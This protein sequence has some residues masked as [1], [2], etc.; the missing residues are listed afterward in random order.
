LNGRKISPLKAHVD[1]NGDQL[2]GNGVKPPQ[3]C[4]GAKQ[5]KRILSCR[6]SDRDL[7]AGFDHPI[8]VDRPT[9]KA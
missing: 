9:G 1:G 7:V 8:V 3:L 4:H 5:G 2:K 6:N